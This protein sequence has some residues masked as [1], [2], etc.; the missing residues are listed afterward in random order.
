MTS[1]PLA[2]YFSKLPQDS[3]HIWKNYLGDLN[4][5]NVFC[6]RSPNTIELEEYFYSR[7][8]HRG[9]NLR[10]RFKK[11]KTKTKCGDFFH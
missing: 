8:C 4:S 11:K 3:L 7:S 5:C 2:N 10:E 9:S 6:S 1:P